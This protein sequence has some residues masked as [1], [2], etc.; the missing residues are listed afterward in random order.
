MYAIDFGEAGRSAVE[1]VRVYA[2]NIY[3]F[4]HNK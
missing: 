2:L 4:F 3:L 1:D